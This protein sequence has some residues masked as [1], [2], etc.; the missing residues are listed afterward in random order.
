MLKQVQ[1]DSERASDKTNWS[2][3]CLEN[4]HN[5]IGTLKPYNALAKGTSPELFGPSGYSV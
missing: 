2:L 1:H 3:Y 4:E 5:I